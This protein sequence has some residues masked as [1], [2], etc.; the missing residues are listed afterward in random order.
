MHQELEITGNA[1]IGVSVVC[2]GPAN[3]P[4]LDPSRP[5]PEGVAGPD[6]EG[7]AE[8]EEATRALITRLGA[9]PEEI[10]AH[11]LAGIRENRFWIFSHE[12]SLDWVEQRHRLI[13]DGKAPTIANLDSLPSR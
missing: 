3:T 4:I 11:I 2:P 13:H 12:G 6:A 10:A 8:Q 1:Q 5:R 7:D 9:E